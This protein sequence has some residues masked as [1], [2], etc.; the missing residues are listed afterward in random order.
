MAV[1]R[2]IFKAFLTVL[3][4]AVVLAVLSMFAIYVIRLFG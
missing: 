3:E 1:F 2:A 4:A